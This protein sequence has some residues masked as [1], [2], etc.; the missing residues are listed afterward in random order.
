MLIHANISWH[1][2]MMITNGFGVVI[3]PMWVGLGQICG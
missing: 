1:V 3:W 2:Q